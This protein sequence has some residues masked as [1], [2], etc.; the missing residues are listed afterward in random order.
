MLLVDEMWRVTGWRCACLSKGSETSSCI[1]LLT[2][3]RR[4]WYLPASY[5]YWR[6][7]RGDTRR[8]STTLP[9]MH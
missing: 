5:W 3:G 1:C 9:G 4:E 7:E 2:V 8:L 6:A